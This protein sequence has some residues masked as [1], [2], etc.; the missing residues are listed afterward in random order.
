MAINLADNVYVMS[1][2]AMVHE[3][4]PQL[5]VTNEEI[6]ARYLGM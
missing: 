4:S 2:G 6:K 1:R 5:L 3:S